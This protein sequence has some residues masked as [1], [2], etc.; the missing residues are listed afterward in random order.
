[1]EALIIVVALFILWTQHILITPKAPPPKKTSGLEDLA[2]A[3]AKALE[4]RNENNY[5]GG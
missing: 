1:M 3:F 4:A 2:K 5:P